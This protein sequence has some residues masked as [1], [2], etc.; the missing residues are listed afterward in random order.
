MQKVAEFAMIVISKWP[1]F[2]PLVKKN[3][4]CDQIKKFFISVDS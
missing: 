3:S 4:F 2:S 1:E